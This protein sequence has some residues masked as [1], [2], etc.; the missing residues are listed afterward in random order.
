MEA[1]AAVPNDH[2]FLLQALKIQSHV[3]THKQ[4]P[5]HMSPRKHGPTFIKVAEAVVTNTPQTSHG[6]RK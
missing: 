5:I 6:K 4:Q 3:L 2:A 1:S